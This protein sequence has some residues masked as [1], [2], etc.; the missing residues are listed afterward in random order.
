MAIQESLEK[1]KTIQ[2]NLLCF[3]EQEDDTEENFQNLIK[4]INDSEITSDQ[5]KFKMLINLLA[6]V[7]QNHNRTPSFFAKFEK[8][9]TIFKDDFTKYYTEE[10]ILLTF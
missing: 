1:M 7:S 9:F 2:S 4:I 6:S 10:E 5:Q 3:L 8:I